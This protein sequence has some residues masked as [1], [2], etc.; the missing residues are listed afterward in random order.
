MKF[1]I[2]IVIIFSGFFSELIFS[3]PKI[4]LKLDD[5]S[6]KSGMC[7]CLPVMDYLLQK[8]LKAG[9]GII[10]NKN[11]NTVLSTLTPYLKAKNSKNEVLFEIWHHGFD[12]IKP[13]FQGTGYEYQKSHFVQADQ[14]INKLLGIQMHSFGSPYNATDSV[15]E[16]VISE[17]QNYQVFMF[18][19]LKKHEKSDILYLDHRVN[20]ENGTGKP[21]YDYFIENYN[22]SKANYQDY[23]ILQGHP[24]QWT[25]EKLDQFKKIIDFLISEGCEFVTPHEYYLSK[26]SK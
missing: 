18:S 21:E 1:R 3:A 11:D 7:Q 9:F 16:K 4:I 10:S 13:E 2:L 5:L 15:T 24:G 17:N 23:M 22:K 19:S 25:T 6:V 20:M 26:N 14:Q 12:H 8:E